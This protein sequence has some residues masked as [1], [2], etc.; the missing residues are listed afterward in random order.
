MGFFKTAE[1]KQEIAEK[2]ARLVRA[3]LQELADAGREQG[4]REIILATG[5]IQQAFKVVDIVLVLDAS[6]AGF[7][8][9]ADPGA[10][11]DGVKRQLREA[12]YAKGG[13]AVI[14][15]QFEY[16]VA[17]GESAFGNGNQ[18]IEIFAYGTVV[19]LDT[20]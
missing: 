12:C 14:D 10:A 11:F 9:D 7:L 8:S 18:V 19:R 6:G 5:G 13:N 4:I 3:Q 1:D 17:V 15:T 16:R 20:R 2:K